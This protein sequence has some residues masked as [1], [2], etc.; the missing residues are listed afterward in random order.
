MFLGILPG[1]K[2]VIQPIATPAETLVR[3]LST[4]GRMVRHGFAFAIAVACTILSGIAAGPMHAIAGETPQ[5][6]IVLQWLTDEQN[7]ISLDQVWAIEDTPEAEAEGLF[8]VDGHDLGSGTANVFLYARDPQAAVGKVMRLYFA[9][10]L[11][12]GMRVGVAEYKDASRKDWD[13]RPVFPRGLHRFD[14]I[15]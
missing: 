10:R 7:D 5:T 3:W 2:G 6:Q 9:R 12:P 4:G 15:Y 11:R 8:D 13:Y 14:L 1:P